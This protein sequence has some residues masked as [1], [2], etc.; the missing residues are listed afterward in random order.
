MILWLKKTLLEYDVLIYRKQF[1]SL[2]TLLLKFYGLFFLFL[3]SMLLI[4]DNIIIPQKI[5]NRS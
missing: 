5:F 1:V 3:T 2:H 4:Y